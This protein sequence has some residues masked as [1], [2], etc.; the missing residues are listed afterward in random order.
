MPSSEIS[1][2]AGARERSTETE[3]E[4]LM[5]E[6]RLWRAANSAQW[7]AWGIVQAKIEG[8]DE[9][10]EAQEDQADDHGDLNMARKSHLGSEGEDNGAE[11]DEGGKEEEEEEEEK[12]FDYL[13][14]AQE[15]ALLFWGDVLQ[16]G[17]VKKDDLPAELVQ[18]VKIVQY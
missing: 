11:A 9:S 4:R 5:E 10:P 15:R 8:M 17:L 3:I 16:L 7:V 12:G 18:K 2:D 14:Y 6:T 1:E 13:A